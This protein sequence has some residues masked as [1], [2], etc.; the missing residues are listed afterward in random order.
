MI[1][2]QVQAYGCHVAT[3]ASRAHDRAH[4]HMIA[5]RR[6]ITKLRQHGNIAI[7]MLINHHIPRQHRFKQWQPWQPPDPSTQAPFRPDLFLGKNGSGRGKMLALARNYGRKL[8]LPRGRNEKEC[9]RT[10]ASCQCLRHRHDAPV[11]MRL[12]SGLK[13]M[14]QIDTFSG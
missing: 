8:R 7:N 4:V 1:L 2:G 11:R 9:G 5:R 13:Q 6:P 12:A 3:L 10:G 14:C